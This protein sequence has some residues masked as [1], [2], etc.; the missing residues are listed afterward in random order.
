MKDLGRGGLGLRSVRVSLVDRGVVG[1]NLVSL[2]EVT[3]RVISWVVRLG[4]GVGTGD[5]TL[6][7]L[8]SITSD[9]E[10]DL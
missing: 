5:Y 3:T 2:N 7:Y 8:A 6:I 10:K 9:L 1:N 4:D